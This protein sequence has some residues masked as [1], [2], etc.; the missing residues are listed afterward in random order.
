M[1][2]M[3][4]GNDSPLNVLVEQATKRGFKLLNEYL[5]RKLYEHSLDKTMAELEG[6]NRILIQQGLPP[7]IPSMNKPVAFKMPELPPDSP[8]P[9]LEPLPIP[10]ISTVRQSLPLPPAPVGFALSRR[11]PNLHRISKTILPRA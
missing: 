8:L 3:G 4:S 10:P 9:P 2:S 5:Q 7:F 6:L 11:S 1:G